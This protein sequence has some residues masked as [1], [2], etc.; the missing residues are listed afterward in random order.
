MRQ[1]LL[2]PHHASDRVMFVGN[3][4]RPRRER[5]EKRRRWETPQ[6]WG[7]AERGLPINRRGVS[8][9]AGP[10]GLGRAV[11]PRLCPVPQ[12]PPTA[13]VGFTKWDDLLLLLDSP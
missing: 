1:P 9:Y 3:E 10:G 2:P 12:V 6:R 4:P 11:S 5:K 13:L 7:R 8:S